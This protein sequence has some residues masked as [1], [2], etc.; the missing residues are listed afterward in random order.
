MGLLDAAGDAVESIAEANVLPI[1]IIANVVRA[2]D[3]PAAAITNIG[4]LLSP[5]LGFVSTL[6]Q[7]F[8]AEPNISGAGGLPVFAAALALLK[9]M[10]DQ[11]GEGEPD[12]G[13]DFNTGKN[14]FDLVA[15][16]LGSA[17][18]PNTWQG[19]GSD[20]YKQANQ[21]QQ[22]RATNMA[23]ADG[24]VSTVLAK[25][26]EQVASTRG[27][28]DDCIRVINTAIPVAIALSAPEHGNPLSYGFQVQTSAPVMALA[29]AT[30]NKLTN[31][32]PLNAETL[33]LTSALYDAIGKD[34]GS[35]K[36]GVGPHLRVV[37]DD[38]RR[39]SQDQHLIASKIESTDKTTAGTPDNV[40][41]THGTVCAASSN[42]LSE[43]VKA[44]T[45]TVGVM[46]D[47]SEHLATALKDAAAR[48]D[49]VDRERQGKIAA[50]MRP[51]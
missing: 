11:C 25:E 18:P 9:E 47:K 20:A 21:N 36:P 40:S 30:L 12:Q 45:N 44:R 22:R 5:S 38:L 26:A 31:T 37:T 15:D 8:S 14:E 28:L 17:G 39:R 49:L 34:N 16:M 4:G 33:K 7:M 51:R 3:D 10:R 23:D 42:A 50:E 1:G 48:Y 6:P 29:Y 35:V 41:K 24:K 32:T 27:T 2:G 13:G 19:A 43:A 46:K